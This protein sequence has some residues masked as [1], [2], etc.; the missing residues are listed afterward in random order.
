M[1]MTLEEALK[2]ME[3]SIPFTA[4]DLK[5]SYRRMAKLYHP[6]YHPGD[7]ECEDI[8]KKANNAHELLSLYLKEPQKAE[9]ESRRAETNK[10]NNDEA[11]RRRYEEQRRRAEEEHRAEERRR[12]AEEQRKREEELRRQREEA[13]KKRRFVEEQQKRINLYRSIKLFSCLGISEEEYINNETA[14]NQ[15][16]KLY[17]LI[18]DCYNSKEKRI[19]FYKHKMHNASPLSF[20]KVERD[21]A[22]KIKEYE[23]MI[24]ENF[25]D[26]KTAA[27]TVA[28]AYAEYYD[29][30][31]ILGKTSINDLE[32]YIFQSIEDKEKTRNLAQSKLNKYAAMQGPFLSIIDKQEMAELDR[33]KR[34]RDYSKEIALQ[35]LIEKYISDNF[36]G[37]QSLIA[38]ID[39]DPTAKSILQS[40]IVYSNEKYPSANDLHIFMSC[41]INMALKVSSKMPEISEFKIEDDFKKIAYLATDFD[42]LKKYYQLVKNPE[43]DKFREIYLHNQNSHIFD[44]K[45]IYE[46]YQ[47]IMTRYSKLETIN[48]FAYPITIDELLLLND[49]DYK[50]LLDLALNNIQKY[51]IYKKADPEYATYHQIYEKYPEEFKGKSYDEAMDFIKAKCEYLRKQPVTINLVQEFTITEEKLQEKIARDKKKKKIN[52]IVDNNPKFKRK[53]EFGKSFRFYD[54]LDEPE[55]KLGTMKEEEFEAV[56][57]ETFIAYVNKY[58]PEI[59]LTEEDYDE[60]SEQFKTSLIEDILFDQ[61]LRRITADVNKYYRELHMDPLTYEE[62]REL[63][64]D[65]LF[66][67]ENRIYLFKLSGSYNAGSEGKGAR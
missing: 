49:E 40:L 36:I 24:H 55:M 32:A 60:A 25:A 10:R 58:H 38:R 13:E 9:A 6:D 42:K 39:G 8:F 7:K 65:E 21:R 1:N 11:E 67:L 59:K 35:Q 66:D 28:L 57:K 18:V 62:I 14:R 20:N 23:N 33:T 22:K 4:D 64:G 61:R 48:A 30:G 63:S 47:I 51:E 50:K 37:G 15:V 45:R 12:R 2:I 46:V 17:K 41:I 19:S 5:K 56:Y 16:E 34:A 3:L 52:F 26:L 54:V 27:N 31:M 29:I 53:Q 44:G 43:F